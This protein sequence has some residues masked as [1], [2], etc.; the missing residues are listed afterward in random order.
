MSGETILIIVLVVLIVLFAVASALLKVRGDKKR[1]RQVEA[2][3][4]EQG[5]EYNPADGYV[6]QELTGVHL[7]KGKSPAAVNVCT[8]QAGDTQELFADYVLMVQRKVRDDQ[9]NKTYKPVHYTVVGLRI[10]GGEPDVAVVPQTMKTRTVGNLYKTRLKTEDPAF[11]REFAVSTR[12]Q[13][14]GGRV[15]TSQVMAYAVQ[16]PR[17]P[18]AITGPWLITWSQGR[19]APD[20]AIQSLDYLRNLAGILRPS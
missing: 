6:A 10:G 20:R 11:N 17:I 1:A 7:R 18:W 9:G 3:A 4:S 14:H 12:S 5:W 16:N 8:R 15:F 19:I 13:K 2:W